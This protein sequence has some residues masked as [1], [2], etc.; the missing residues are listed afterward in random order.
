MTPLESLAVR[1]HEARQRL[2]AIEKQ[3]PVLVCERKRDA[4]SAQRGPCWRY[5]VAIAD[6]GSDSGLAYREYNGGGTTDYDGKVADGDPD[7]VTLWCATCQ[8]NHELYRARVSA[9][10]RLGALK[11][12][13]WRAAARLAKEEG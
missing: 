3:L 11:S 1:M 10:R 2:L 12:A 8:R 7:P 9:S 13:F 5:D 4:S 6:D